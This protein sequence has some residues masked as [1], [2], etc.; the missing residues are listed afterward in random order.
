M[1][2]LS[3]FISETPEVQELI[4]A[5]GGGKLSEA[6]FETW[7]YI[8][9]RLSGSKTKP[10]STDIDKVL[11]ES[12]IVSDGKKK[13][14]ELRKKFGDDKFLIE[15]I[16]LIGADIKSIPNVTWGSSVGIVHNSIDKYYKAIPDSYKTKGSKANTADMVFVTSGSIADLLSKLPNSQLTWD[17]QG[18]IT[19]KDTNISFVQVSLKK[20]EDNA[21][22]GKLNTLI[23]AIYGQQAMRPTQLVNNYTVLNMEELS[24]LEEGLFGD[25]FKKFKGKLTKVLDWAKGIL[26]KLRNSILKVGIRAIR[27]IQKDKAHKAASSLLSQTGFTISEAAGDA[28]PINKPMLREMKILKNEIIAKD[29]ANAEY[30]KILS[31]VQKINAIKEGA[32]VIENSGTDPILEMNNFKRA[33]D[34]V[35]ERKEGGFITREELFPA[36]KLCVNYASY[37]TFNTILEDMQK[38]IPNYERATDALVELNAKLKAE[39]MFGDTELPLWIVYG[40]GGGAHYK[41]TKNE[42]EDMTG[43]TVADLGKSMDVP[44]MV[45]QIGRSG[46]KEAYNSIYLLM[47][48]GSNNVSGE[49]K[50]EYIKIQFINRSGSGFSYKIDAMS[51]VSYP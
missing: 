1:I 6:T 12:E 10:T 47:L 23:N 28:V 49:L 37:K 24:I 5:V 8:V 2:K 11:A 17:K 9:A 25:I 42:F 30:K 34:L 20:G 45:I 46:G 48:S 44:Y 19:I 27:G 13:I 7:V 18:L 16:E 51:T 21:R 40:T 22:I 3:Q 38:K 33:A 50:P 15:A 43:Q 32:V 41:H 4:K 31:N 36:L 39:A 26:V 35:L 14:A 29:M